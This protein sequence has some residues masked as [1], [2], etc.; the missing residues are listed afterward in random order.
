[1][2]ES[3][4]KK[5]KLIFFVALFSI[6]VLSSCGSKQ[7]ETKLALTDDDGAKT[8]ND[9]PVNSEHDIPPE[10]IQFYSEADFREFLNAANASEEMWE[11]Y[12]NKSLIVN[13][14]PLLQ[15]MKKETAKL[16]ADNLEKLP[17]PEMPELVLKGVV[18]MF[19]W[20]WITFNYVD[21][22]GKLISFNMQVENINGEELFCK[23]LAETPMYQEVIADSFTKLYRLERNEKTRYI[24]YLSM[25]DSRYILI[26]IFDK[27]SKEADKLLQD[28]QLSSFSRD[29]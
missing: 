28:M 18:W 27:G 13:Q 1:M 8:S 3:D 7:T 22:Q 5:D 9:N 10:I 24:S 12:A 25:I 11:E 16:F 23:N 26:E 19:D 6:I 17:L 29:N 20:N 21:V 14:T 2:G 15:N 4:V